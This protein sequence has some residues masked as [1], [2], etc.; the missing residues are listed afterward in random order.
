MKKIFILYI[1][2]IGISTTISKAQFYVSSV[3]GYSFYG[4]GPGPY[5]Y[6]S[7]EFGFN[8]YLS[9]SG[10]YWYLSFSGGGLP[11]GTTHRIFDPC[12]VT[13]PCNANWEINVLPG[14]AP[15]TMWIGTGTTLN[16][17]ITSGTISPYVCGVT[18]GSRLYV[19]QASTGFN[20]GTTWVNA[21]T[22]IEAAFEKAR[23]CPITEIWVA[24]GTYKPS[25]YPQSITG[26]PTLTNN[27][28]TF[29]LVDG[30][31]MY[32]GFIGNET[33]INDRGPGHE[34]ILSGDLT[35]DDPNVIALPSFYTAPYR[36]NC[37]HVVL[38]VNDNPNTLLD[39]F[40]IRNGFSSTYPASSKTIEGVSI[41][42]THG[43]GIYMTNGNLKLNNITFLLNHAE[44]G[45]AVFSNNGTYSIT[46][47]NF[48]QNF[49]SN[50][51]GG[52]YNN[53][54]NLLIKNSNFKENKSRKG[55]SILNDNTGILNVENSIFENNNAAFMDG[56]IRQGD[57]G[58][59]KNLGLAYVTNSIFKDNT[60][61]ADL[62]NFGADINNQNQLWVT[63]CTFS[64]NTPFNAIIGHTTLS[65]SPTSIIK[66]SIFNMHPI[67][68]SATGGPG[69]F[70]VQYSNLFGNASYF[71]VGTGN[72]NTD[73][74]FVNPADPDGADNIWR[75]ADDGFRLLATSPAINSS[76]IL[77]VSPITDISNYPRIGLFDRG[78][79]EQ[80]I[81][82]PFTFPSNRAYVNQFATGSNNGVDWA[83]AFTDLQS[84]LEASRNCGVTEIWVAKGTYK[85]SKDTGGNAQPAPS[86]NHTFV[87]NNNVKIYG[88]FVGLTSETT[89]NMAK[90]E[91]NPTILSGD[92]GIAG[93]NYD[94][95]FTIVS[96]VNTSSVSVLDGFTITKAYS[97]YYGATG[98]FN[99]G[100]INM[101]N[102]NTKINNCK[103]I[104][105]H[106]DGGGA[107]IFI[108]TTGTSLPYITNC[109][110]YQNTAVS[111]GSPYFPSSTDN[112]GGAIKLFGINSSSIINANIKN[113]VFENNYSKLG[114][115][116]NS[117]GFGASFS[118]VNSVFTNNQALGG[119]G[120]TYLG[121]AIFTK[122]IPNIY[123]STFYNNSAASGG[124]SIFN[125]APY[126]NIA[127]SIFW[128][129]TSEIQ[130]TS[131]LPNINYNIIQG[132]FSGTGN[133]SAYPNFVNTASL[134]GID[135]LWRTADD[136]LR[137][138]STSPALNMSDPSI[139][140]IYTDIIGATRTPVYDMGAYEQTN[141]TAIAT[142]VWSDPAIW[143]CGHVPNRGDIATIASGVIVTLDTNA[144]VGG[145]VLSGTLNLSSFTITFP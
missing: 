47:S 37:Y 64:N 79:Y 127:N 53:N 77:T 116:I 74:L 82:C 55:A 70:D 144:H 30:V 25:A 7:T 85:P 112:G 91:L 98:V 71:V 106:V 27:D 129:S 29:H 125:T 135:N 21:F 72:L 13:P 12:G 14:S 23:N 120:G 9:K 42:E 100:G 45:G 8:H 67:V 121:G 109:Y 31:K 92:I 107:A 6:A 66:N 60:G 39:N 11:G 33:S 130:S 17:T 34:T 73:P 69:I 99:G 95:A 15:S 48:F 2:F 4:S 43:G 115:A 63:N 117:T 62:Y 3:P 22:S 61:T 90:P 114:G 81:P 111:N 86:Y 123:N 118:I 56:G 134:K 131:A 89:V 51:G 126:I 93:N 24:E 65:T 38:S 140:D 57:G 87:I 41:S 78:S 76:D 96:I 52:I 88:G 119:T 110:F 54:S 139:I 40:T 128:G 103:F 141:C 28:L 68:G 75:T 46:N 101:Y 80:V 36:N 26:S 44:N 105:N 49:N 102:G 35:G 59:I 104:N 137:L 58:G 138:L 142:G 32:G 5:I 136:G 1:F 132:G 133:I 18:M 108:E 124:N 19:N 122:N 145:L 97:Y 143:S 84:A 94:N 83:N 20:T 10:D 50:L 16:I 113:C